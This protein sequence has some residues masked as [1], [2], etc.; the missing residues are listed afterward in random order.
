ME[1]L[2]EWLRRLHPE[3]CPADSFM[4]QPGAWLD[5]LKRRAQH[6]LLISTKAPV[7]KALSDGELA[8]IVRKHCLK[9]GIPFRVSPH[10]L[11]S[12]AITHALD[13]GATHRGVQQMAGW[14]SPLMISRYDKKRMDPQYSAVHQLR[15]GKKHEDKKIDEA[16]V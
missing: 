9:A 16:P 6:P 14:T 12:T 8:R 4:S 10:M 5:F 13:Q 2:Q 15:Y 11:R 7:V 1:T 3:E